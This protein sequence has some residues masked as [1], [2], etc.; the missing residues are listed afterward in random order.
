[1]LCVCIYI[2]I[3]PLKCG[4]PSNQ[5]TF[6]CLK[7]GLISLYC[8]FQVGCMCV[9]IE[10]GYSEWLL[11]IEWFRQHMLM[12]GTINIIPITWS[13]PGTNYALEALELLGY[14]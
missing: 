7:G 11:C 10:I 8:E 1:M 3:E 4:H 6:L 5:A 14:I 12:P 2:V 9:C 13:P